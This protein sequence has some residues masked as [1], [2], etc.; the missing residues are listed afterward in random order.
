MLLLTYLIRIDIYV[1]SLL[2]HCDR[3]FHVDQQPTG[4]SL[5]NSQSLTFRRYPACNC[6]ISAESKPPKTSAAAYDLLA[7]DSASLDI[8]RPPA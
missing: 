6:F 2:D 1:Q 8:G 3:G 5:C 4:V 7:V